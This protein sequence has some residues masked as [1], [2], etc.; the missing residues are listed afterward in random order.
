MARILYFG[1]LSSIIGEM[2]ETIDL[3]APVSDTAS[4]RRWIDETRGFDGALLHPSV[5]IAV[6]N[7]IVPDPSPVSDKDEIAFMPPV[8][9]G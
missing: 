8:G 3:P 7:E 4:L 9:G 1:K 6:N 2:S 5:R